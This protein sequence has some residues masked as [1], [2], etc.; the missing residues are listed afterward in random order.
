MPSG[1]Q[2]DST[3]QLMTHQEENLE[4]FYTKTVLQEISEKNEAYVL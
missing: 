2:V 1:Y 4:I 3:V